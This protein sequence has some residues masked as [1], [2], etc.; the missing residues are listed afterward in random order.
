M[1]PATTAPMRM[2][3]IVDVENEIPSMIVSGTA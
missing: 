3:M 1:K 2:A